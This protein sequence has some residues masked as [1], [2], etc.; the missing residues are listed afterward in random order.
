[1]RC[2]PSPRVARFTPYDVFYQRGTSAAVYRFV[3]VQP[4]V[5]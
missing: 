1:M 4:V 3:V 2:R 5:Q